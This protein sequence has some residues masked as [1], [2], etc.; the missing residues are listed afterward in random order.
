MPESNNPFRA[1]LQYGL[2]QQRNPLA[3]PPDESDAEAG[4]QSATALAARGGIPDL[5]N[6]LPN[7]SVRKA[8]IQAPAGYDMA[9]LKE[10]NEKQALAAGLAHIPVAFT[11]LAAAQGQK[12]DM[13]SPYAAYLAKKGEG[14][15]QRAELQHNMDAERVK[16]L[17]MYLT[18]RADQ[19]KQ[20][21]DQSATSDTAIEQK[22][23]DR[24]AAQNRVNTQTQGK[25][26]VAKIMGGFRQRALALREAGNARAEQAFAERL[27][28]GADKRSVQDEAMQRLD[29][30]LDEVHGHLRNM[31]A[32][33]GGWLGDTVQ[34]IK[35]LAGDEADFNAVMNDLKTKIGQITV[36]NGDRQQMALMNQL[37][38]A[39]L[40]QWTGDTGEAWERK[41]ADLKDA[42]RKLQI[43]RAA[44]EGRHAQVGPKGAITP[45][46]G[47]PSKKGAAANPDDELDIAL[48]ALGKK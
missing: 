17:N 36:V 32:S 2:S 20:Y 42:L 48:K 47:P 23:A 24:E 37:K 18:G 12:P 7:D 5:S 11:R 29:T 15:Q 39:S 13:S 9:A 35:G 38:A 16:T 31:S 26:D 8:Q 22:R 14:D 10:A 3:T 19:V 44:Q 46:A 21:A 41:I 33:T 45:P 25:L 40:P 1:L 28:N 43:T 30:A 6:L 34:K 4:V 27:A